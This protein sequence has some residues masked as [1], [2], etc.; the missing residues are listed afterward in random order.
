MR[1]EKVKKHGNS[2]HILALHAVQNLIKA[3][4]LVMSFICWAKPNQ[5]KILVIIFMCWAKS[6][7]TQSIPPGHVLYVL[8]Q[9]LVKAYYLVMLFVSC[10]EPNESMWP[11]LVLY[12]LYKTIIKAAYLVM[13]FTWCSGPKWK[14]TTGAKPT[15]KHTTWFF[16]YCA[17]LNQNTLPGYVIYV[18]VKHTW[19]HPLFIT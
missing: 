9:H 5:S 8:S 19:S 6:N 13:F 12:V 1:W 7:Q 11:S 10:S 4:Y 14:H 2:H 15:S 18:L 16:M 3:F 17:E